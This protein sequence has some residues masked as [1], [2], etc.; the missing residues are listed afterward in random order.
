MLSL[1]PGPTD[2]VRPGTRAVLM[3]YMRG[4]VDEQVDDRPRSFLDEMMLL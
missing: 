1:L 3:G 2:L 4:E